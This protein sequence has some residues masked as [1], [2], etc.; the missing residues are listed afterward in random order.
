MNLTE[1]REQLRPLPA[2]TVPTYKVVKRRVESGY[3]KLYGCFY[4]VPNGAGKTVIVRMYDDRIELY[5][6]DPD[7]H[8]EDNPKPLKTWPRSHIQRTAQIDF[9]CLLRALLLARPTAFKKLEEEV[10]KAMFPAP[11]FKQIY[12]RLTVWC[13]QE[14]YLKKR[15]V[16]VGPDTKELETHAAYEYFRIL[17]LAPNIVLLGKVD[18]ALQKLLTSD[19]PFYVEDVARLIH[20]SPEGAHGFGSRPLW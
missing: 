8:P 16:S 9:H 5:R 6:D 10:K 18:Q 7:H 15:S 14:T 19:D 12:Q 20:V 2:G 3:I 1:E 11:A 13:I 4:G 17:D